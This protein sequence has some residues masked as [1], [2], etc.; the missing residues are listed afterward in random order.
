MAGL[1]AG[2]WCQPLEIVGQIYIGLLQM[3]VLPFVV[4][5]LV[6]NLGRLDM[7][8]FRRLA[9]AALSV[10]A[11]MWLLMALMLVLLPFALPPW[12]SGNFFSVGMLGNAPP[13]DLLALFIPSNPFSALAE[14]IVPAVVLFCMFVG[15][16]LI[17]VENRQ[18][19]LDNL[20]V[21]LRALGRIN[22]GLARLSPVGVFAIVAATAGTIRL[23][24]LARLQAYVYIQVG[25]AILVG[26]VL[27]PLLVASFTPISVKGFLH[28][29][30]TPLLLALVT[31]KTMIVLPMIADRSAQLLREFKIDE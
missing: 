9:G 19:L 15:V 17:G 20:Q 12:Q 8:T 26:L 5:S 30:W 25:G 11:V 4:L 7:K 24:E 18:S 13:M 14:N 27:I 1:L 22:L 6:A 28:A 31:G 29:V 3:T 10:L 21:M 2:E 23:D 16:G